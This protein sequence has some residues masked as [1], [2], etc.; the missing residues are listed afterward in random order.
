MSIVRAVLHE[1]NIRKPSDLEP[2]F[3]F[4]KFGFQNVWQPA[5]VH[6]ENFASNRASGL[7]GPASFSAF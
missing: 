1:L 6:F 2:R 3:D 4:A 7:V 5:V